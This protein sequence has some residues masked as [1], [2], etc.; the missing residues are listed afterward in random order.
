MK[1]ILFV[2]AAVQIL[3]CSGLPCGNCTFPVIDEALVASVV[4][5][6]EDC[7]IKNLFAATKSELK[8]IIST[9]ERLFLV[10]LAF[11]V[12]ETVCPK[13]AGL[14]WAECALKPLPTAET[15]SCTS[16]VTFDIDVIVNVEVQCTATN[17][18]TPTP[19]LIPEFETSSSSESNESSDESSEDG[20]SNRGRNRHKKGIGYNRNCRKR[21]CTKR[22][23]RFNFIRKLKSGWR[24]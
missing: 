4:K 7:T 3:Y 12:Q 24:Y 14:D 9:G 1:I 22:K 13:E 18:I 10:N 21:N 8:E 16:R 20:R 11:D 2:V 23:K 17:R 15:A 5:L 19:G 6:N